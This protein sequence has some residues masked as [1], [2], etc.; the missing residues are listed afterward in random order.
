M[1]MGNIVPRVGIKP[2]SPAFQA[3]VLSLHNVGSL[4]SPLFP[5]LPVYVVP[6]LRGQCRL[7]HMKK[8]LFMLSN[9]RGNLAHETGH[10]IDYVSSNI[11]A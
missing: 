5:R 6:R 2:M 1:K 10:S 9:S 3:N 8:A 11:F 4:M 7:L